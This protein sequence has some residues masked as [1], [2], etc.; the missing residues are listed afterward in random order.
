MPH[1]LTLTIRSP[2]RA[3]DI[4]DHLTF[5]LTPLFMDAES[6][7]ASQYSTDWTT[8]P[9]S[10]LPVHHRSSTSSTPNLPPP[11]YN[12]SSASA[13]VM[14]NTPI[15]QASPSMSHPMSGSLDSHN[16]LQS[17]TSSELSNV[18]SAPLD[19]DTFAVLAASG[20]LPPPLPQPL[21]SNS[22]SIRNLYAIQPSPFLSNSTPHI[23]D[24]RYPSKPSSYPHTIPNSGPQIKAKHTIISDLHVRNN[25][26]ARTPSVPNKSKHNWTPN[27]STTRTPHDQFTPGYGPSY[28]AERTHVGLPPSLWMSPASTA[29]SSPGFSDSMP[30]NSLNGYASFD[31]PANGTLPSSLHHHP[32]A[33]NVRVYNSPAQPSTPGLLSITTTTST[34]GGPKSPIFSDLFSDD[35]RSPSTTTISPQDPFPSR[36]LSGSPD[37]VPTP[38]LPRD[39]A[40]MAKQDPLV[41]QV[42]KMYARTK[43]TQP[44]AHRMENIT[45]RMMALVLQKK[46]RDDKRNTTDVSSPP[47]N[48]SVNDTVVVKQESPSVPPRDLGETGRGRRIDKGKATK[49]SVVGFDADDVD[50]PEDTEPMDWRELSRSRSRAPMDWRAA[51]R[52]RSRPSPSNVAQDLDLSSVLLA[53]P[54]TPVESTKPKQSTLP[55]ISVSVATRGP[56]T[57][58]KSSQNDNPYVPFPGAHTLSPPLSTFS[59]PMSHPSSL[60]ALGLHGFS[61]LPQDPP[62]TF[63]RHVRKTS[64]DHTVTKDGILAGVQGRHQ[65]NG[66]PRSPG[67]IAGTK[68]VADGPHIES[69]LRGDILH[70]MSDLDTGIGTS[71]YDHDTNTGFPSGS[72]NFSVNSVNYDAYFDMNR[73][74]GTTNVTSSFSPP[75]SSIPLHVR[76]KSTSSYQLRGRTPPQIN[77]EGLSAAAVA[78]SAAVA[79]GYAQ[80]GLAG[81]LDDYSHVLNFYSFSE[82]TPATNASIGGHLSSSGS[83]DNMQIPYTHVDPTQISPPSGDIDGTGVGSV[84]SQ[85]SYHNT[86]PSSDGWGI[87]SGHTSTGASPEPYNGSAASTPPSIEGVTSGSSGSGTTSARHP[88]R[89][90]VTSKRVAQE[91]QRRK[92]VSSA[93]GPMPGTSK[94]SE[95]TMDSNSGSGKGANEETDTSV[96][97]CRNCQ[98][99]NTPLWRRDPEG[100]PLCNACGLFYKLHG[101]VRPQSLKTDVIKKRNRTNGTP[102]SSTTRKGSLSSKVPPTTRPRSS[103]TTGAPSST[104]G[105]RLSPGTRATNNVTAISNA[106]MKRQRRSSVSVSG[107]KEDES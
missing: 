68:R 15:S 22:E 43:A 65:V 16:P 59:S 44:H 2:S 40:A 86:S 92:S 4:N 81:G 104:V 6:L 78:A 84:G 37:L 51:S 74:T 9:I 93:N 36:K 67:N 33:A 50:D 3:F 54:Q 10:D 18:F 83:Y 88:T 38:D 49:I 20:M 69:M 57:I 27:P 89:K 105:T 98:T 87:G 90:I 61:H 45:W 28:H 14:L 80:L 24:G 97:V 103:T 72:F 31:L 76:D 75:P 52:S 95:G 71:S 7:F 94:L 62:P 79:E 66:K 41:T 19:P 12:S 35:L 101:V 99:T 34:A 96:T 47:T 107:R 25:L 32:A 106:A 82:H 30:Y 70:G 91:A 23:V 58:H 64:F 85:Q 8:S 1:F 17:F 102:H 55:P 46:K 63:P 56:I 48:P 39:P 21:H 42:W 5:Q 73:A 11:T 26:H 13:S 29:P 60:P 53:N 100:Q 77:S